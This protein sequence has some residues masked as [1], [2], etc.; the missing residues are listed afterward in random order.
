MH[1][2]LAALV[3]ALGWA[4]LQFV[5]QGLLIGGIAALLLSLLRH[6]RPQTRYAVACSALLLCAAL[7]L[8]SVAY[9]LFETAPAA[10]L[11][12]AARP[13][14]AIRFFDAGRAL[15]ALV[16]RDGYSAWEALL[17]RQI[18]WIVM[19]WAVGAAFM[20]LRL[21]VGLMWVQRH[22][23]ASNYRIDAHWQA[24][25]YELARRFGIERPVLLGVAD[26]LDSPITA[27]WWQPVVLVPAALLSGMSTQ[28]LEALLAHEMAHIKRHDYLVNLVQ[29]AIEIVLFYHPSVWWLSQRIR[30]ERE[31][32][33]DD[34]AVAVLGEPRRL[35]LALSELD[36]FQFAMPQLAHAAHG[37]NLMSRITR[38]L[39]PNVEPLSWKMAVPLLGLGVACTM[40][41]AQAAVT[42]PT[43]PVPAAEVPSP[44]APAQIPAPPEPPSALAKRASREV[45][46]AADLIERAAPPTPPA[47]PAPPAVAELPAPPAPPARAEVTAPPAPP[48]FAALLAPPAPPALPAQ[49]ALAAKPALPALPGLAAKPALPALPALAASAAPP[50]PPAPPAPAAPL[51]ARGNMLSVHFA[52]G[53]DAR[54]GLADGGAFA[55]VRSGDRGS[56]MISGDGDLSSLDIVKSSVKGDFI[57]FRDGG[58]SYVIQDPA[59]LAKVTEAWQPTTKLGAQ[60]S[61]YGA[62]MS[63]HGKVMD[64]LGK[65]M[66]LA[67]TEHSR[68]ARAQSTRIQALAAKQQAI[69]LQIHSAVSKL[70][71]QATEAQRD[72]ANREVEHLQAKMEALQAQVE[73]IQAATAPPAGSEA[74]MEALRLQMEEQEKPMHA[75]SKQMD[76][77]SK[78]HERASKQAEATTRALLQEAMRNGKA[79]VCTDRCSRQSLNAS[80]FS[81]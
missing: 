32:I 4:L 38:L 15:P 26:H 43:P 14:Q 33:A 25:L 73:Q 41:Y 27:G 54:L 71:P 66:S 13:A 49:P 67:A 62:Q 7:P 50:A 51:S 34:L 30:V 64:G 55:L 31:Q 16:E 8:F 58:K 53:G 57:W 75:L 37:G 11:A 46:Q 18:P 12:G 19:L 72:A 24:Q 20:T 47:P 79:E 17:R 3:G 63:E 6:A 10:S 42:P 40:L 59:T 78:E 23:S 60:M 1:E 80:T 81:G 69:D 48:A 39:R 45:A 56:M 52:K 70:G 44:T 21:S 28:L 76:A 74:A 29:S 36:R 61:A 68:G 35:A 65:R 9:A 5:W 77:L 22:T 2:L